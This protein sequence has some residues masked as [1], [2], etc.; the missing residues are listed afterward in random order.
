MQ[1]QKFC[2]QDGTP[3]SSEP[4]AS[5]V[6]KGFWS[7]HLSIILH[8]IQLLTESTPQRFDLISILDTLSEEVVLVLRLC[9]HLWTSSL[10]ASFNKAHISFIPCCQALS[11]LL[12]NIK[13]QP[14]NEAMRSFRLT[15]ENFNNKVHP[16]QNPAILH[17]SLITFVPDRPVL[18]CS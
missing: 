13:K 12:E 4:P 8:R 11:K 9:N 1:G 7:R 5:S 15:N 3:L 14:A 6:V 16:M 10:L 18:V 17:L 2:P